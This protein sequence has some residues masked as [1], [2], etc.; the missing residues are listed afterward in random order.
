MRVY[1]QEVYGKAWSSK[2]DFGTVENSH[3]IG[4][5][6]TGSDGSATLAILGGGRTDG[7]IGLRVT[8]ASSLTVVSCFGTTSTVNTT[9][10]GIAT[11]PVGLE[12]VYVRLPVGV[13]ATVEQVTYG[14]DVATWGAYTT[15]LGTVTSD[16]VVNGTLENG[17]YNS[18]TE[19]TEWRDDASLTASLTVNFAPPG[20][21][22]RPR[23]IDR[24]VIHCPTPWQNQS[25]LLDYDLE[26]QDTG[27]SWHL[28]ATT[29]EPT[30]T[31]NAPTNQSQA[32]CLY[33]TFHS[34]R[35]IFV[36]TF[37]KV[38]AQA[39]RITARSTTYGGEPTAAALAAGGQGDVQK[40]RIREVCA[41]SSDALVRRIVIR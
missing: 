17:Y 21:A 37:T 7:S 39:V 16:S 13:T 3:Y 23:P 35:S 20:A 29:T 34:G 1:A 33:D 6:F 26:Y 38:T 41:Y 24:V 9:G 2:L 19:P 8:G 31:V 10:S 11:I 5:Q 18:G 32:G 28:I 30:L 27:G 25:T 14:P 12:P 36:H 40:L 15:N 4:S 22:I